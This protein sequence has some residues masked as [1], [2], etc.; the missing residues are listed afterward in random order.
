M[1]QKFSAVVSKI[2]K[3]S[4]D[5]SL[6]EL[7]FGPENFPYE[8]GGHLDVEIPIND[9][10]QLRSYSLISSNA[11]GG[12]KIAVKKMPNSRGGSRYMSKLQ[13]GAK[14]AV[15]STINNLPASYTAQNYILL[16]GGIGITPILSL[17]R[18]LKSAGKSIQLYY[19]VQ[20]A[21]DAP[22][23]NKLKAE[24]GFALHM[25]DDRR[26]GLFDAKILVENIDAETTLY[27]CGPIGLMD[28][29]K[30]YWNFYK[31]KPNNLR[32]E[33]FG[34][35]GQRP[36]TDFK[37]HIAETGAVVTVPCDMT[38][39]DALEASGQPVIS[40]CRRGECGLCKVEIEAL[41]GEVDHRDVFLSETERKEGQAM[42]SC[43]SRVYGKDITVRIDAI[44]HGRS[45]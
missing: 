6:F 25:H 7:D 45:A 36:N 34:N 10:I 37:V 33:T 3:L 35:S 29:V 2:E 1:K 24:F 5:V 8:P 41:D 30:H 23:V 42:C 19:C 27:M 26:S 43:V 40:D 32:F 4:S 22:F 17:A 21:D 38:M 14:L 13:K 31:L 39:L 18:A 11:K 44:T 28:S 20:N 15:W 9:L 12:V 16:A